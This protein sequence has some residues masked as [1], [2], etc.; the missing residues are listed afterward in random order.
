MPYAQLA[1]TCKD[2]A[3]PPREFLQVLHSGAIVPLGCVFDLIGAGFLL[4][5]VCCAMS[6]ADWSLATLALR[7]LGSA[8][9]GVCSFSARHSVFD[10]PT[11]LMNRVD[12]PVAV[13][14]SASNR[15]GQASW[16]MGCVRAFPLLAVFISRRWRRRL[17]HTV[18]HCAG[19]GVGLRGT[20]IQCR[21]SIRKC[22][23]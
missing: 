10:I 4:H 3:T 6:Y 20:V 22:Q 18:S 7:C 1:A 5:D 14:L 17:V 23:P 13:L 8:F 15:S 21:G 11:A 2:L 19:P 12:E 16:Q 9:V